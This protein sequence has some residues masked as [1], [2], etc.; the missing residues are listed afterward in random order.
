MQTR[1][2][3]D[4]TVRLKFF[5]KPMSNNL[6]IQFG[7][8]LGKNVIFSSLRQDLVRR[9][10]HCSLDT[11]WDERLQVVEEYIQLLVNRRHSFPFIKA[12]VQISKLGYKLG[13]IIHRVYLSVT[14][15]FK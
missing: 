6:F 3:D 10:L 2:M 7:T 12:V 11:P 8:C 5:S 9:M 4:G 13:C 14:S 15:D 1:I